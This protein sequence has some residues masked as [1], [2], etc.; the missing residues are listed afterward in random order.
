MAARPF[1]RIGRPRHADVLTPAEWEVLAGLRDG[2]SNREVADRRRCDLETV[3]FHLRNLRRKLDVRSRA[4]LRAFPGRPAALIERARATRRS[5]RIREQI[6]LIET[7]DV[8]RALAFYVDTLGFE[9]VSRW[10]D[11]GGVPGWVALGSGGARLMIRRSLEPR[12]AE[13]RRRP[14]VQPNFYVDDL[15][16]F[17]TLLERAGHACSATRNLF[18]GARE[19]D[20]PDPDGNLLVL[21][22]FAAS[23]PRYLASARE[24]APRRKTKA[25]KRTKNRK[26]GGDR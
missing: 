21:V 3:R 5:R 25:A 16:G 10:P 14:A 13:V 18:Y 2:L 17:R 6:P 4:E 7:H 22:E 12:R 24:S 8:A 9:I 26:R 23:E 20:L 19:L 11:D 1:D 15:D